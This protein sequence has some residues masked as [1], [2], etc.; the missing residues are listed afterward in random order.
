MRFS[1]VRTSVERTTRPFLH[2]GKRRIRRQTRFKINEHVSVIAERV[3][4]RLDWVM[5]RRE[6]EIETTKRMHKY[7]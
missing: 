2:R 4:C 3:E 1:N 5:E 6:I 7:Q